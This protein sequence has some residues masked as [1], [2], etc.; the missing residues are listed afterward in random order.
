MH[1]V[2]YI[3][4]FFYLFL[5][6]FQQKLL[7]VVAIRSAIKFYLLKDNI[8][9]FLTNDDIY[10]CE[11]DLKTLSIIIILFYSNYLN[12]NL[13]FCGHSFQTIHIHSFYF[14]LQIYIL[15]CSTYFAI[16]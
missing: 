2:L 7:F 3:I 11:L 14:I 13:L 6:F 10:T 12:N 8:M 1:R 5:Y 9:N 16:E 15:F 4:S